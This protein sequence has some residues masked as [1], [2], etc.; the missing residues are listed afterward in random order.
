MVSAGFMLVGDSAWMPKPLDAG[1]IGPALVAGTI[2][3]KCAAEAVRSGDVSEAGLWK[4]N[5][6]FIEEY[7]YKTAGLEVF[8]RL[9]QTLTNEQISYGMK[10]FMG[11]LDVEAISKGE[12]PDF[13]HLGK[14]S[15]AIR[16]AL[17]KRLA[18]GLR[19]TTGQNRK[20]TAHYRAYP[21]SPGGFA[22]WRARLHQILDESNS[23]LARFQN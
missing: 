15:M 5:K 6:E 18:D 13:G 1:G 17:N 12:H 2:A 20:L 9:I 14:L 10:H 11:N 16:G 23:G 22:A 21:E 4:Y 7:G 3:G 8:R 19:F